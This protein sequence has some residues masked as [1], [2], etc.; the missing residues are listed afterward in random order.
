[1]PRR[2]RRRAR[3]DR[4]DSQPRPCR[5][6]AASLVGIGD[7][8]AVAAPD[9]GALQVL[10]TDALVEGVHFDRR[11]SSP[12]TSA[13]RRSPSTSATSPRWAARSAVRAAVADAPGAITAR[14]MSTDCSTGCSSWRRARASP[15]LAAT[16]RVRPAR[17][18]WTS[19]S[20]GSVKPRQIL[21]RSGGRAGRR[22]LRD[23]QIG[24]AAAGLAGCADASSSTPAPRDAR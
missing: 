14:P 9:R 3:A 13:T 24:A 1:M 6:R 7:D 5:R 21:T 12:R 10:T 11:F 16:S 4:T 15:W 8:A 17:S 22:P 19:P 20:I 2:R 23:R 18:S